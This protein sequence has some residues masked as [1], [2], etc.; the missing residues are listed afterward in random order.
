MTLDRPKLTVVVMSVF[1]EDMLAQNDQWHFLP[2]PFIA[3]KLRA[4]VARLLYPDEKSGSA[5]TKSSG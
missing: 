5:G 4:L 3:S 2:K 1:P